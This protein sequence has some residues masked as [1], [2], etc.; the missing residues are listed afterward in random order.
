MARASTAAKNR[1]LAAIADA[2]DGA[3]EE[4]IAANARDLAAARER[5]L[6][7]SLIDRLTPMP[8]ASAP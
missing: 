4:L 6:A 5:R 7:E 8:R 2:I 3:H 1:A